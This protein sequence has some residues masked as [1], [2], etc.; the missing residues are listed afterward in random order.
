M[1][2]KITVPL[3][4]IATTE[5]RCGVLTAQHHHEVHQ[6]IDHIQHQL[7]DHIAHSSKEVDYYSAKV[8][9]QIRRAR[10]SYW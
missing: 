7:V 6:P 3:L 1:I 8:R 9:I 10:S 5:V 2:F 4:L